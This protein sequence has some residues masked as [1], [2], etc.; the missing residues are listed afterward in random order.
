MRGETNRKYFSS[1][2]AEKKERL[3]CK[4]TSCTHFNGIFMKKQKKYHITNSS[5]NEEM[6]KKEDRELDKIQTFLEI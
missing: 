5:K 2:H 1:H 6:A 3:S 4:K